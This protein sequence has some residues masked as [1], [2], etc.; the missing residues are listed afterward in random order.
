MLT[1]VYYFS[2]PMAHLFN[3]VHEQ[4]YVAHVIA[5]A[6]KTG[7]YGTSLANKTYSNWIVV[8]TAIFIVC[9]GVFKLQL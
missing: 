3:S 6:T 5:Y 1:I 2:G 7:R 8:F 4:T 9:S